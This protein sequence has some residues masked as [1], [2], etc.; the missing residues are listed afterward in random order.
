VAVVDRIPTLTNGEVGRGRQLGQHGEVVDS[1]EASRGGGGG[2]AHRRG[3]HR[4]WAGG[5][6][7]LERTA[8]GRRLPG[9]NVMMAA[10]NK[11]DA[12]VAGVA[13]RKQQR[14]RLDS[15][16]RQEDNG[17]RCSPRV[18]EHTARLGSGWR[19]QAVLLALQLPVTVD[20][21]GEWRL[22]LLQHW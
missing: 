22:R 12:A 3:A 5:A 10:S 13:T 2:V 9:V 19:L 15:A 21:Q 6:V 18:K 17:T 11:D 4:C 7:A 16:Q 1:I 14:W 8:A 20:E